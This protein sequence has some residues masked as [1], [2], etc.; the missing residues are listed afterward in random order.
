[1]NNLNELTIR[2]G[3]H[4]NSIEKTFENLTKLNITHFF[5]KILI[6]FQNL[7]FQN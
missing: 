7:S 1:M 3:N 4:H 6:Q 2:G 5:I